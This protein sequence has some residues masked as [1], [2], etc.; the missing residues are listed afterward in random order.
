MLIVK[1]KTDI[2]LKEKNITYYKLSKL[3]DY[4]VSYLCN[5]FKGKNPF[6]EKLIEKLLPILEVSKEE[7]EGWIL[8][9]KYPKEVL[10]LVIQAK[11]AHQNKESLIFTTKID[12]ILKEKGLSRTALSKLIKHSQSGLNR[13][14]IAKEPL[15]KTMLEKLSA[16]LEIS[17]DELLAWKIADKYSLETLKIAFNSFP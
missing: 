9:D 3:I 5:I 16:G 1:N 13:I 10:K 2:L 17:K 15:S 7:F 11:E 14:I 12:E 8:A 6:P 4:D